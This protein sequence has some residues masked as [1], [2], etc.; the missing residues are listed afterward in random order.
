MLYQLVFLQGCQTHGNSSVRYNLL[1]ARFE[2]IVRSVIY[3]E[4]LIT[5]SK[6]TSDI[7]LPEV[8]QVFL[9]DLSFISICTDLGNI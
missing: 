9:D 6:E 3:E 2:F 8:L 1:S 5:F 4:K 7:S